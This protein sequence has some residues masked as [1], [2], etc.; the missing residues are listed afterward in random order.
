[1]AAASKFAATRVSASRRWPR[2]HVPRECTFERVS[3]GSSFGECVLC[4]QCRIAL[5][6]DTSIA[7][8]L[9]F[10]DRRMLLTIAK[11]GTGRD[12]TTED[13]VLFEAGTGFSDSK[14]H[15]YIAELQKNRNARIQ[16]ES[17]AT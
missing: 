5:R 16:A 1:M 17:D 14:K 11:T 7:I 12:E 2:R 3:L 4:C 6:L 13:D 10:C 9:K 15:A 8:L